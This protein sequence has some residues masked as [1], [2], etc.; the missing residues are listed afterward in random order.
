MATLVALVGLVGTAVQTAAAVKQGQAARAQAKYSA[1]MEERQA[2]ERFAIA[3]RE[4]QE[5]E[6]RGEEAMSR[7]RAIAAASGAGGAE[8]P[9][10]A[11]T[12]DELARRTE[13]NIGQ[14]IY[15]GQSAQEMGMAQAQL[16]RMGGKSAYQAGLLSGIGKGASGLYSLGRD[17]GFFGEP[18]YGYQ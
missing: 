6:R 9:S 14:T 5:Q 4:A 13:Y 18:S 10:V 3:S 17:S 8:T 15:G 7:A 2:A 1:Q 16:T 12:L 11:E